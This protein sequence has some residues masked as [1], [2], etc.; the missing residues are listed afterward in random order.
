MQSD[1]HGWSRRSLAVAG[2]PASGDPD[3]GRSAQDRP[4]DGGLELWLARLE[5]FRAGA[6]PATADEADRAARLADPLARERYLTSRWLLRQVLSSRVRCAP[7]AL[8]FTATPQ[9]K[10]ALAARDGGSERTA[11]LHFNLSH[12]GGW[13]LIVT[14]VR[15]PV[16]VDLEFPRSG[17]DLERLASRVLSPSERAVWHEAAA[18]HHGADPLAAAREGFFRGWTRKEALLKCLGTG[19]AAG[20]AAFEVGMAP[21]PRRVATPGHGIAA[22]GVMSIGLPDGT[23]SSERSTVPVAGHAAVAWA[24]DDA[25]AAMSSSTPPEPLSVPVLWRHLLVPVG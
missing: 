15:G 17:V 4:P 3:L 19:F 9:G 11:P 13:L 8:R 24:L 23:L 10:P 14:G 25:S 12:A 5:D 1:A 18:G 21:L 7:T 6:P 16:G 20:A 2:D 22:V